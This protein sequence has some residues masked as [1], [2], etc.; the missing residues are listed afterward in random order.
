MRKNKMIASVSVAA[1]LLG[2]VMGGGGVAE[3]AT[4]HDLVNQNSPATASS[5]QSYN[6][7]TGHFDPYTLSN[8]DT[9]IL[10]RGYGRCVLLEAWW[11]YMGYDPPGT[12]P[13]DGLDMYGSVAAT[14]VQR[15]D[16]GSCSGA[17]IGDQVTVST[18]PVYEDIPF[19]Q[20]QCS[21][22]STGVGSVMAWGFRTT[23][24]PSLV[25]G[26]DPFKTTRPAIGKYRQF[27]C[28][29][30]PYWSGCTSPANRVVHN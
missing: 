5:L 6:A 13:F 2:V 27:S 12:G 22:E 8:Q 19:A 14:G 28:V 16:N 18:T 20:Y 11:D 29:T 3:A 9:V 4:N 23:C 25:L 17:V 21:I 26:N 24:R 15:V 1:G 10:A 7:Y 30:T